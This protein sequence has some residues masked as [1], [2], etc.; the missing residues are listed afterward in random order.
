MWTHLE[1]TLPI[2]HVCD[3][4]AHVVAASRVA[5]DDVD[6]FLVTP[7]GVVRRRSGRHLPYVGRHVAQVLA[8]S[9][10]QIFLALGLVV[11]RAALVYVDV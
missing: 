7:V 1:E 9:I 2:D 11:Y 10:E 6:K 4:L 8:H 5:W 3:Q